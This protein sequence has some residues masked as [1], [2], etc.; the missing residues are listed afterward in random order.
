MPRIGPPHAGRFPD[1]RV[2]ATAEAIVITFAGDAGR[3]RFELPLALVGDAD[4]HLVSIQLMDRL[5]DM[6]YRV[7]AAEE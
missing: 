4:P 5:R 7:S 6:G 3:Q 2:G 1:A